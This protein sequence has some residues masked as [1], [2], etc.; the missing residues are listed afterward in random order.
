MPQRTGADS[1]AS[2][3][4]WGG[5]L[6]QAGWWHSFELPDGRKIDGVSDLEGLK[7]RSFHFSIAEDLSGKRVLDIGPWDGW[8]SFEMERRGAEVISVDNV[9]SENFLYLHRELR[10]KIDYRILD[11]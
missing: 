1:S 10:S 4:R 5:R 8:F 6:A 3:K 7:A 2:V 9:E 11:V